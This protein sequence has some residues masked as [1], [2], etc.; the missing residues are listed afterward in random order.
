MKNTVSYIL[1]FLL[2][3]GII[4]C[5]K[6]KTGGKASLKGKVLHHSKPIPN[7]YVYI[8]FN[9]SEYPGDSYTSYDTYVEADGNGNYSIPFYQGTYYIFAMGRDM[10][11]PYPYTVKGGLSISIRNKENLE[12]DI[13]VTED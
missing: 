1:I 12:K 5:T 7:A 9:S 11:I 2:T 13:A 4:S 8:K 6:N 3:F 10:D